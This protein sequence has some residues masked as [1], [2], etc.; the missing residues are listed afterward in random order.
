LSRYK[1]RQSSTIKIKCL[2]QIA[3]KFTAF[4]DRKIPMEKCNNHRTFGMKGSTQKEAYWI[5]H[6]CQ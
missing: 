5:K 6:Q 1:E 4:S 3:R 2:E